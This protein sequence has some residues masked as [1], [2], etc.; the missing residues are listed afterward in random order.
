MSY[1]ICKMGKNPVWPN[2]IAFVIFSHILGN[3]TIFINKPCASVP[4][5][6]NLWKEKHGDPPTPD[7]D[8]SEWKEYETKYDEFV[9]GPTVF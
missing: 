3:S 4:C 7:S 5:L 1:E 6:Y 2:L 8:L 9:N